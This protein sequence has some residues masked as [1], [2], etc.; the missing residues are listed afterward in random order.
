MGPFGPVDLANLLQPMVDD[1][2][3]AILELGLDAAASVVTAD[4]NLLDL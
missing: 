1:A 3:T 2:V 4:N